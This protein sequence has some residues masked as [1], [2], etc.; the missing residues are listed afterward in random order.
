MGVFL[1]FST[2]KNRV[3]RELIL[4]FRDIS[5]RYFAVF[6]KMAGKVDRN[7]G[8]GDREEGA[9]ER[10]NDVCYLFHLTRLDFR[11]EES[12]HLQYPLPR[13]PLLPHSPPHITT[14]PYGHPFYNRR[15]V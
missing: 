1:S 4:K 6:G 10:R 9:E 5:R 3:F 8:P 11:G 13:L 15:G 14:P 7:Q 2:D 12:I